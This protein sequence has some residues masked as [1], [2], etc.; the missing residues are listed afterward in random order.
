MSLILKI[1]KN[2]LEAAQPEYKI[3]QSEKCKFNTYS[4]RENHKE[5]IKNNK[6]ILK[7]QQRFRSQKHN[8]LSTDD[9]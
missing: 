7:Y 3:N 8:V 2:C 1:T 9:V 6:L 5:S 4:L